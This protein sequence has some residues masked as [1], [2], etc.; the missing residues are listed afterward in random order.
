MSLNNG[1]LVGNSF[2]IA[3]LTD[4]M[5]PDFEHM[6]IPFG[7]SDEQH[8]FENLNQVEGAFEAFLTKADNH[9]NMK[10]EIEAIIATTTT[11][12]K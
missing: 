9:F 6:R 1:T 3:T 4:S 2:V 8:T 12:N 5:L 7:L 10:D 11:E